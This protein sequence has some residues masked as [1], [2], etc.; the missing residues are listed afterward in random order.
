MKYLG[1]V[2]EELNLDS[3]QSLS[4]QGIDVFN[5]QDSFFNDLCHKFD[6][7]DGKDIILTDRRNE[8]YQNVSFCED[9]CSYSSM[10]YVLLTAICNCDSNT[11]QG[12]KN[13]TNDNKEQSEALNFNTIT[14][15]FISNLLDFNI[16]VIYCYNLVFDLKRLSKNI[17]FFFYAYN[18]TITNY[19]FDYLLNQKIKTNKTFHVY[20]YQS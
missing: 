8:L 15:S 1:D 17:G 16:E 13:A 20:F 7:G 10:D 3:A 5:A 6:N 2:K 12:E 9:G 11:L 19:F 14:K 18:D 4:N